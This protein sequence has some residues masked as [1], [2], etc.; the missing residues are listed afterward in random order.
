MF[1]HVGFKFFYKLINI[2]YFSRPCPSSPGVPTYSTLPYIFCIKFQFELQTTAEFVV[3]FLLQRCGGDDWNLS[4]RANQNAG[5]VLH[6]TNRGGETSRGD[7]VDCPC[8][9]SP[10]SGA[11]ILEKFFAAAVRTMDYST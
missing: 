8:P 9:T 7:H 11:V 5:E 3:A 10:P 1:L 6:H 4:G 2:F